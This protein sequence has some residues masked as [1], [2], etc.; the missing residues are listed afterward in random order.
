MSKEEEK[1]RGFTGIGDRVSRLGEA[2]SEEITAQKTEEEEPEK[3]GSST[4]LS[5]SPVQQPVAGKTAP[6]VS[7]PRSAQFPLMGKIAI[8]VFAGI[9]V[10]LIILNNARESGRT[11]FSPPIKS[12]DY[13]PAPRPYDTRS[14]R[15]TLAREIEY[16][17]TRVK[18]M[19]AQIKDMDD[20]LDDYERK[21]K[22]YR[23]LGMRDEYNMLVQSFNSLVNERNYL[24]EEYKRLIDEVNSKVRRYNLGSR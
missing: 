12:P 13:S 23:D 22:L 17:K 6:T 16:E 2:I 1:K 24:Y 5:A 18:Q 9:F 7:S 21:M 4:T 11:S 20:R 15:S 3:R 8:L 10:F 14:T 19:E